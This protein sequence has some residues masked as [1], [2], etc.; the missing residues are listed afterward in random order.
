MRVSVTGYMEGWSQGGPG[1]Y[2]QASGKKYQYDTFI[3]L[4]GVVMLDH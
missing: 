3:V 2:Y 4:P 1:C